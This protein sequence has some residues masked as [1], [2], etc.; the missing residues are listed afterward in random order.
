MTREIVPQELLPSDLV[1]YVIIPYLD[2]DDL[3]VILK[4]HSV[5]QVQE[6]KELGIDLHLY[7]EYALQWASAS[8]HLEVV[9]LLIKNGAD[10]HVGDDLALRW[11]SRNGHL[12]IVKFLLE[13]GADLHA[14]DDCA[15]RAASRNGHLEV[16]ELLKSHMR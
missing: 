15:L 14:L 8:G 13:N 9:E 11:A 10:L 1:K 6:A 16:V 12:E 2:E 7:D 3:K 5:N 4:F